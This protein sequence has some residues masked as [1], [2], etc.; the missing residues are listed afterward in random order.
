MSTSPSSA[1]SSLT[2]SPF[3]NVFQ[4]SLTGPVSYQSTAN[5]SYSSAANHPPT[6]TMSDFRARKYVNFLCFVIIGSSPRPSLFLSLELRSCLSLRGHR[7]SCANIRLHAQVSRPHRAC[8]RHHD[9]RKI[10]FHHCWRR[11]PEIITQ[12]RRRICCDTVSPTGARSIRCHDHHF[13]PRLGA[14]I[15]R[16]RTYPLHRVGHTGACPAVRFSWTR[17]RS[18]H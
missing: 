11:Q 1:S 17:L 3:T 6:Y 8:S 12:P 15:R 16:R 5:S 18:S 14:A 4:T 9:H 10:P 7:P 13:P 2:F